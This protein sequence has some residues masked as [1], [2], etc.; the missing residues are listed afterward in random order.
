MTQWGDFVTNYLHKIRGLSFLVIKHNECFHLFSDDGRSHQSASTQND[1]VMCGENILW[2]KS[3]LTPL[4][5]HA[6]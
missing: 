4:T 1:E 6:I 2:T 3:R 5:V